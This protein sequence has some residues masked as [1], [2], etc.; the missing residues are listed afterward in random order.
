[1]MGTYDAGQT[2]QVRSQKGQCRRLAG[3]TQS[4]KAVQDGRLGANYIAL[5]G[6][7]GC[8]GDWEMVECDFVPNIEAVRSEEALPFVMNMGTL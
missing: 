2:S 6:L 3:D 8:K 4:P 5:Q 1:M 7:A